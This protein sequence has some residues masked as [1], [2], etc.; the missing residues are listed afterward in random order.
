MPRIPAILTASSLLLLPTT[1]ALAQQG[2]DQWPTLD[3]L[4]AFAE[5]LLDLHSNPISACTTITEPGSYVLTR[6]LTAAADCL[7]IAA[8]FVT[9]DLHG[10]A[11]IGPGPDAPEQAT[12]IR[13]EN[14]PEAEVP[15]R[16]ITVRNGT[17][18][19]FQVG[20]FLPFSVGV[21]VEEVRVIGSEGN[22]IIVGDG[23]T[24]S[25]NTATANQEDGI[26]AHRG[27]T[28]SGNTAEGNGAVGIFTNAGSTVS[29]N[30]AQGNNRAGIVA[31]GGGSTIG[32]NTAQGNTEE[33]IFVVCPSNVIGNTAVANGE[34]LVLD[35]NP[36]ECNASDNLAP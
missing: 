10:W 9:L 19:H 20:V 34:N 36:A 35:G 25:G 12:G 29:G 21:V 2:E 11:I 13:G 27:S 30:T 1:T 26:F 28:V 33:G 3:K 8:D 4:Q 32:G 16:G 17:I 23:S 18:A 5:A 15:Q 14:R 31:V 24:V 7:V 22:G 6:N